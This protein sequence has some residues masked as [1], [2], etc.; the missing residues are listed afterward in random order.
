MVP[1]LYGEGVARKKSRRSA[2]RK[3]FRIDRS[4]LRRELGQSE[5]GHSKSN[6]F[7]ALLSRWHKRP[8]SEGLGR[9]ELAGQLPP[10]PKGCYPISKPQRQSA[11]RRRERPAS[12]T[13]MSFPVAPTPKRVVQSKDLVI[14]V[15]AAL[16]AFLVIFN[17]IAIF[18]LFRQQR[19]IKS[20]RAQQTVQPTNH[21]KSHRS[22]PDPAPQNP[23]AAVA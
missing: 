5:R 10:R 21:P 11:R 12:R 9:P 20:L 13:T 6:D 2:R 19:E 22:T 23:S 14:L 15:L 4:K 7:L 17:G 8:D 3:A 1:S 16:I 18:L